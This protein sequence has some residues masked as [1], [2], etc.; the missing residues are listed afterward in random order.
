MWRPRRTPEGTTRHARVVELRAT[1]GPERHGEGG[2]GPSWKSCCCDRCSQGLPDPTAAGDP[3]AAADPTAAGAPTTRT[4]AVS[5]TAAVPPVAGA[6]VAAAAGGQHPH[7]S[8]HHLWVDLSILRLLQ[9]PLPLVHHRR[10]RRLHHHR[11][12][13]LHRPLHRHLLRPHLPPSRPSCHSC[14]VSASLRQKWQRC[15]QRPTQQQKRGGGGNG[16]EAVLDG[17]ESSLKEVYSEFSGVL[18]KKRVA[19]SGKAVREAG[20]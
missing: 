7:R 2:E 8:G 20:D 16:E 5:T 11:R 12:S 10:R 1:A 13:H 18:L 17:P 14:P 9:G 19:G 6:A 3:S 4:A 15:P